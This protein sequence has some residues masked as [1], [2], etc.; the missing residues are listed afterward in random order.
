LGIVRS[1]AFRSTGESTRTIRGPAS[2]TLGRSAHREALSGGQ[3]LPESIAFS[4]PV[5]DLVDCPRFEIPVAV[6][7]DYDAERIKLLP[8]GDVI[9]QTSIA[10]RRWLA[11]TIKEQSEALVFVGSY[12]QK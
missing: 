8:A 11:S 12:S 10:A 5:L 2:D 6:D 4:V 1:L 9:A 3:E 7:V